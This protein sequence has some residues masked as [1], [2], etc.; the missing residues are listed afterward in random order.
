MLSIIVPAR[1]D[2]TMTEKCVTA[3]LYSVSKLKLACEFVLVDDASPPSENM[4]EAFQRC[5]AAG[6]PH[7]FK[8]IR[9]NKHR[10]YSGVFSIGLHF[11]V[12]E[13]MFFLSN[14]MLV[15]PSFIQAELMVSALSPKIGVVR[16]TSNYTDSHPEHRVEPGV[17]LQSYA[18]IEMFS[19]NVLETNGFAYV[20]D[21]LL[22]GDAV[23]I[24]RS[25]VDKIGVL[26]LRFFGYYG[27]V[28]YGM[29]A[30][31]AGF[32]LVCAKGAWLM[33][34]GGG[35]IRRERELNRD[36]D[37][38]EVNRRRM[39]TVDAAYQQ[40]REKW[41]MDLPPK[42]SP[43][44]KLHY[45]ELARANAQRVQ[46]KYELPSQVLSDLEFF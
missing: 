14:D 1:N 21:K 3:A 20:E 31:L 15:T 39:A 38:G 9:S 5:R 10:H 17:A 35:H 28:D 26:D 11:S 16:G 18:D 41:S 7:Q 22:S 43:N 23:L 27:D 24:R 25:L 42:Y 40:F 29:R 46:L 4:V 30:H 19:K 32:K 37:F 8:I 34:E 2:A 44:F 6:A 36:P 33:H 12:G 45:F 13:L